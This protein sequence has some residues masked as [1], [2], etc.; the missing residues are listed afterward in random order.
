M[1]PDELLRFVASRVVRYKSHVVFKHELVGIQGPEWPEGIK[2][3]LLRSPEDLSE[4]II[5]DLL[6]ATISNQAYLDDIR[7][8][9][10]LGI[11][12]YEGSQLAHFA[13]VMKGSATLKM[14]GF[15]TDFALLGNART[16]TPF[17]GRG[18]QTQSIRARLVAARDAGFR[19][20]V[21]ETSP[22]NYASQKALARA[23]LSPQGTVKI[24]L[25]LNCVVLRY[26]SF[27]RPALSVTII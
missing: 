1:G 7:K 8:G 25:I 26:S 18:L 16:L 15:G 11:V 22:R 23:G 17:R 24:I 3:S 4:P 14:L 13:F 9:T 10:A 21:S 2:L 19:A 6:T 20:A 5:T 12:A 27:P